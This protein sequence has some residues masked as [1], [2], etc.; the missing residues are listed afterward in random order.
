MLARIHAVDVDAVGLGDLG[1]R[2]GYIE[3]QLRRWYGQWEKSKT[4][5]LPAIDEVH[6]ALA[7]SCPSRGRP[8]SCTATTAS[9]TA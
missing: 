6:A 7:A 3:R 9:T 2:E 1:R 8:R 5:E 4:R